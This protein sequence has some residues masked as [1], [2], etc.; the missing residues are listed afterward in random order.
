MDLYFLR[1]SDAAA[2]SGAR[3]SDAGRVL[4]A[5]GKTKA[6]AI[7]HAMKKMELEFD[8]ILSSPC[9]R[10]WQTAAIV[11]QKTGMTKKVKELPALAFGQPVTEAVKALKKYSG[12]SRVLLVGHEP[13][14]SEMIS[15][16]IC[17]KTQGVLLEL[18]KGSLCKLSLDK[19]R[20]GRSAVLDWL[21]EAAQMKRMK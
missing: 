12:N 8:W 7:G 10:A 2:L 13:Q 9:V 15:L 1:H 5:A 21:V 19:V 4:T 16:L 14:F 18:K 11:A 6:A 3:Y 20:Y 17:G